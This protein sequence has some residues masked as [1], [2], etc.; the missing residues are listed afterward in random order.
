MLSEKLLE[1][2]RFKHVCEVCGLEEMLTVEEAYNAGWDYPPLMGE[3]GVVSPRTCPN[4]PMMATVWAALT[5]QKKTPDQISDNQKEAVK[6]IIAEPFT[7]LTDN[8]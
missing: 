8:E 2:K 6:R 3:F 5:L 1:N 4:C 7:I